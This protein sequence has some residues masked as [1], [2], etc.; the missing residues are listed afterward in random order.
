V[1]SSAIERMDQLKTKIFAPAM[2][3]PLSLA[4]VKWPTP[5]VKQPKIP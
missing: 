4:V 3:S 1:S 2:S 5:P